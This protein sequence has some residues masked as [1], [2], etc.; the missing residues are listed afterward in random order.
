MPKFNVSYEIWDE[1]AAEAGETDDRGFE[2]E[3]GTLRDAIDAVR[4]TRTN[5]VDGV[6]S[7]V[8]SD[9]RVE[10]ARWIT[11]N[12]GMEFETGA[13]ECRSLHIPEGVTGSSRRRIARLVGMEVPALE[14]AYAAWPG[15]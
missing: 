14:N 12:N 11:V 7:V 5:Q 3:G 13:R 15:M 6:E 1:A 2:L 10:H 8:A 4:G 9:S